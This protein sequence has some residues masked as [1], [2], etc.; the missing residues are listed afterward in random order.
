MEKSHDQYWVYAFLVCG[1]AAVIFYTLSTMVSLSFRVSYILFMHTG[2]LIA[3][4]IASLYH[5]SREKVPHFSYKLG[6]L[7]LFSSGVVHS[8]MACMQGSNRAWYND[9]HEEISRENFIGIFSSQLGVD[10]VFDM[11]IS[12]GLFF[13][14]MGLYHARA[15]H[16]VITISGMVV[17]LGGYLVNAISFPHNPG[18]SG[19]VD[20]GPYFSIWFLTFLVAIIYKLY[21]TRSIF[22]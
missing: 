10:F 15:M 21:K 2:I 13:L 19:W 12:F 4:S 1:I 20:P 5:I 7:L 22:G 8:I 9:N 14:C 3:I 17:S 11:T 18:E 16:P 6:L